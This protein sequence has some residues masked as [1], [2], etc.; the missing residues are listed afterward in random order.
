MAGDMYV[1]FNMRCIEQI[2]EVLEL[3]DQELYGR[4]RR[5]VQVDMTGRGVDMDELL[6]HCRMYPLESAYQFYLGLLFGGS[7]LKKMLPTHAE[8]L[9]YEDSQTL[10]KDFKAYL[11]SR[12][13]DED[14][15]ISRVN[16]CYGLIRVVFDRCMEE[17]RR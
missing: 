11:C 10:I 2:Q 14:Q 13:D 16:R 3:Q 4:L 8:F 6:E 12:V 5:D 9:T 15:F 1:D 7:M 17:C